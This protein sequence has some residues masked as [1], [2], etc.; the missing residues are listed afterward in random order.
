MRVKFKQTGQTGTIPDDRFD[1]ALFEKVGM[2]VASATTQAPQRSTPVPQQQP[3]PQ[4]PQKDGFI[5]GV[6]KAVVKPGID[7]AKLVMGTG[8]EGARAIDSAMGN[9]EAYDVQKGAKNPFISRD[10]F[11]KDYSTPQDTLL[12]TTKKTAAAG[13]YLV[14][15]GTGFVGAVKTG[16]AA[17]S[18]YG[19]GESDKTD[20]EGLAADTLV[21]A[22]TGAVTS[23]A[24]HGVGAGLKKLRGAGDATR[25]GVVKP[26]VTPD[27]FMAESEDA[28]M[29]TLHSRGLTG[30][31]E[32]QKQQMPEVFRKISLEIKTKLAESKGTKSA[33]DVRKY[34]EEQLSNN[35]N[36][37]ESIPQMAGTKEK[38]LNELLKKVSD[39]G[40]M[41]A[42]DITAL[43]S[44]HA[45]SGEK[46]AASG[47]KMGMSATE[48]AKQGVTLGDIQKASQRSNGLGLLADL[49]NAAKAGDDDVI[50]KVAEHISNLPA[51]SPYAP[52][53]HSVQQL[54]EKSGYKPSAVPA[55]TLFEFKQ[56]LGNKLGN[57][58]KKLDKGSPLTDKEE[59]ALTMW[60][61]MDDLITQ[62][63]PAVKDMTRAQSHLYKA[64]PGIASQAKKGYSANLLGTTVP[65]PGGIIQGAQ[66]AAGRAMQTVGGVGGKVA[67]A[68]APVAGRVL[69]IAAAGMASQPESTG[70]DV[71]SATQQ[72][73]PAQQT[74]P[75]MQTMEQDMGGGQFQQQADE[76]GFDMA[77]E[78]MVVAMMQYDL[79][80]TGGKNIPEI[81]SMYE[82]AVKGGAG[83]EKQKLTGGQAKELSDIETSIGLMDRLTPIINEN[84]DVMGPVQGRI[85]NANE[86]DTKAQTFNANIKAAA[87]IVG[88][89]MEGGVLRQED[90]IKYEKMLP[91]IKDTPEL[92]LNK[93]ENVKR[94]LELQ[95]QTKQRVYQNYDVS[96]D[97]LPASEVLPQ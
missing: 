70:M 22:G 77:D 90:T 20:A 38:L 25:K 32:A 83:G 30:S 59:V 28:I 39:T 46:S 29:N 88:K 86:Y 81:K 72:T 21:G 53:L 37:D 97:Y 48:I 18:L 60:H 11:K 74:D 85:S 47:L 45:S 54:A 40:K 84:L 50:K 5:T 34:V 52:Y 82:I 56:N 96:S 8:F 1:P 17:G 58:F 63:E 80:T 73:P 6:A 43:A 75:S 31:A 92:A 13:S 12:N 91:Q 27:P 76:G 26:K 64:M 4:Q 68:V 71:L 55:K 16:A 3:Q 61:A 42:D 67:D 89:A 14:P 41:S 78:D 24:A 23:V 7:F 49:D 95:M 33:G 94:M 65:L 9:K 36:F 79:E 44:K 69:P 62:A 93:I 51:D 19:F 66:D 15:G 35:I 2:D 10:E 87:Q 57:V